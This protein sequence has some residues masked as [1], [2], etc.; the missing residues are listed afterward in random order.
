MFATRAS[1]RI[2]AS[3]DDGDT[4]TLAKLRAE[5][6]SA[7]LDNLRLQAKFLGAMGQRKHMARALAL[8]RALLK[9]MEGEVARLRLGMASMAEGID[10][11]SDSFLAYA[12]A[13]TNDPR[14]PSRRAQASQAKAFSG[15]TRNILEE[16]IVSDK[17]GT[18][19][20][21]VRMAVIAVQHEFVDHC[22][23]LTCGETE[24]SDEN[25]SE[26]GSDSE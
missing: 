22:N 18:E 19:D 17:K 15:Q 20:A 24:T 16:W 26:S 3:V 21:L 7:T 4:D 25:E 10:K 6:S 9:E 12:Q 5:L 23:L 11:L 13:E 2:P 1:S 14:I 8:T